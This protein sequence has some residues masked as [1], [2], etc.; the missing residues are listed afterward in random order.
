MSTDLTSLPDF[1]D[2]LENNPEWFF[3][4]LEPPEAARE[5]KTTPGGLRVM[6]HRGTGPDFLKLGAKILY[7]RRDLYEWLLAGRKRRTTRGA[8]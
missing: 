7:V 5:I 3:E 2:F 1:P 8:A 4:V 6:R